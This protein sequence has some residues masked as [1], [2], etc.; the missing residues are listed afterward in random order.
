MAAHWGIE[1]PSAA[2]DPSARK[3]GF[4]E[5]YRQLEVWIDALVAL[6]AGLS[7]KD[8]KQALNRIGAE[9]EGAT[10]TAKVVSD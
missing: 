7:N 6:P 2:A 9:S 8:M 4:V 3:A 10:E 1:D 5:A